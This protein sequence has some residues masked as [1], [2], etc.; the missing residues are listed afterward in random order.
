VE[1]D[2]IDDIIFK[3]DIW[4]KILG[5]KYNCSYWVKDN[6]KLKHMYGTM[7]EIFIYEVYDILKVSSRVVVD[8]G[9]FVCYSA[10]YFALKGAKRAIAI[11]P[12]PG[13]YTEMLENIRLNDLEGVIIPLNAGLAGKPGRIRVESV[14]EEET[15]GTF[16]RFGD[17]D[18]VEAVTLDDIVCKFGIRVG[19]ILKMDCEGCE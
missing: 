3:Y 10:I 14:G 19:G 13:A 9:A 16:H 11:E 2:G 15:I 1:V 7:S 8:V 17:V 6:V 5:W 18:S 4:A 12:H